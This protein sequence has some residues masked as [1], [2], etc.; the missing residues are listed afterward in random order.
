MVDFVTAASALSSSIALVREIRD[1]KASLD[2]AELKSKMAE[3][4]SSLA[5]AKMALADAQQ[6]LRDKYAEIDNL[7]RAFAFKEKTVQFDGMSYEVGRGATPID[8]PFCPFCESKGEFHR[9]Y[10]RRNQKEGRVEYCPN[11]KSEYSNVTRFRY[12][13]LDATSSAAD[14]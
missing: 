7:K 4:Y 13:K 2:Q 10:E 11:C 3:L 8:D 12:P 6:E 9:I 14:S 1:A 5:D